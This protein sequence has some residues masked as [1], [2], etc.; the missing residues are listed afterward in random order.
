ML[1]DAVQAAGIA[2]LPDAVLSVEEI[3]IYK[4]DAR[5]YRIACRRFNVAPDEIC[6]QSSNAWDAAGAAAFGFRVAWINRTGQPSEYNFAKP[7]ITLPDLTGLL[8][9]VTAGHVQTG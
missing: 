7:G 3:G 6:F 9:Y 5:V 2:S 4:P 1:R 8:P